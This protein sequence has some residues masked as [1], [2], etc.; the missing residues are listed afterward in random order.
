MRNYSVSQIFLSL[1]LDRGSGVPLRCKTDQIKKAPVGACLFLPD[2]VPTH[3]LI[4]FD[5]EAP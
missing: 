2:R 5:P 3:N 1:D 4:C